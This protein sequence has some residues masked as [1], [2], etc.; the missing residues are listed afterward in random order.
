[1]LN[2]PMSGTR[3]HLARYGACA[4]GSLLL[5][6]ILLPV[7]MAHPLIGLIILFFLLSSKK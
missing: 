6:V 2:T 7:I 1:V 5:A 3:P 4:C